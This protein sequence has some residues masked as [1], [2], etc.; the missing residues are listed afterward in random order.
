MNP[1]KPIQKKEKTQPAP[2]LKAV[3]TPPPAA[4]KKTARKPPALRAVLLKQIS[5]AV[6][7]EPIPPQPPHPP[8]PA[9]PA[10]LHLE[11]PPANPGELHD[12]LATRLGI[13]APRTAL[14]ATS[15]APF[16]YLVHTFFEGRRFEGDT[17]TDERAPEDIAVWASRGGGKTFLGAV[18]T[19]LD[20]VFKPG[21]EVRI[22]G[23]SLEQSQRMLEHLRRLFEHPE[24]APALARNGLTDRRIR[25]VNRSR[26]EVLAQSQ[27]SV[28]GTRVQK[29]RCDEAEL[30]SRDVWEAAQLTTRS[31]KLPGPWGP[32]VRGSVEALST[33]HQPMGLMWEI[34]SGA[35]ENADG[36]AA[37]PALDDAPTSTDP[38]PAPTPALRRLFRWSVVDALEHCPPERACAACGLRAECAGRAKERVASRAG[39]VGIDDALRQKTR[40]SLSQWGS[41]MLCLR[42]SRSD[43]VYPEFDDRV[44]VIRGP[45]HAAPAAPGEMIDPLA[46]VRCNLLGEP[47]APARVVSAHAT[48]VCGMDFGVRSPTVIL[49]ALLSGDGTLRVIDE[50][51]AGGQTTAQHVQRIMNSAHGQPA[52]IGVDPAGGARSEQTLLSPIDLLRQA[53]IS[54]RARRMPLAAGIR[55]VQARLAPALFAPRSVA[56]AQIEKSGYAE[57]GAMTVGADVEV[58]GGDDTGG[59]A[60]PRLFFHE[61]CRKLI[62]AMTRYHYDAERR[63]STEPA[64]DGHDHACDALR[65]LITNLDIRAEAAAKRRWA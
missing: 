16:D 59:P 30:F 21:I 2:A 51:V 36:L 22:L 56:G 55:L 19:M 15:A 13:V 47:L 4:A 33:M 18:A 17:P 46:P 65:Y 44:H 39:H 20:L 1:A 34:V 35:S 28:R 58:E 31:L 37:Q 63:D 23:G 29:V 53:G 54:V 24:L 45:V 62:E 52:W 38:I 60:T 43:T 26:A 8:D 32:T 9:A 10:G 57:A 6:P 48:L 3:S 49:W 25:L 12:L 27:A 64:K 7:A 50:H 41:E 42:P 14:L 40:V 5:A 11:P 61:R